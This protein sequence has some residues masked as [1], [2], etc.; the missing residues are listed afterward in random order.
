MID[1]TFVLCLTLGSLLLVGACGSESLSFETVGSPGSP[2]NAGSFGQPPGVGATG[3]SGSIGCAG[4]AGAGAGGQA[5]SI[6]GGSCGSGGAVNG[7]GGS[8]AG[9]FAGSG[10]GFAGAGGTSGSAGAAGAS[11]SGGTAGAS[12]GGAGGAGAN[13][14]GAA[15]PSEYRD[16]GYAGSQNVVGDDGQSVDGSLAYFECSDAGGRSAFVYEADTC[17]AGSLCTPPCESDSQCPALAG[18]P[19]AECRATLIGQLCALPCD[20]PADC[21]DGMAC[22]EDPRFGPSCLFSATP[23]DVG[24]DGGCISGD[25]CGATVA[26][27]EGL[28]CAP[29]GSCEARECLDFA[30]PCPTA[31]LPCCGTLTCRDG[32]C[33]SP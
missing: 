19:P 9:G 2:G 31:G 5:T 28:V 18:A 7:A 14:A 3:G 24:C 17:T 20:G 21:P 30:W 15:G 22:L 6:L 4:L 1:R 13:G 10:G 23:A 27:C 29:W 32:Y 11:G 26:C 33:Q 8:S 12:T 16:G 25:G